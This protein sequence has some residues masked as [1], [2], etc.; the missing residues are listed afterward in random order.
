MVAYTGHRSLQATESGAVGGVRTTLGGGPTVLPRGE[1]GRGGP[2]RPAG[3]HLGTGVV[4]RLAALALAG[5][6]LCLRVGPRA[7]LRVAG[8]A[9]P[10]AAAAA[11]AALARGC[12]GPAVGRL[13]SGTAHPRGK[14]GKGSR[15]SKHGSAAERAGGHRRRAA[16]TSASRHLDGAGRPTGKVTAAS[17]LR[18]R[19]AKAAAPWP[20]G[21]GWCDWSV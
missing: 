3:T 11:A 17:W 18:Q 9:A 13:E 8:G 14:R 20:S 5:T 15:V 21:T 10:T 6:A 7:A 4:G 16:S 12:G 1:A 19:G 2:W